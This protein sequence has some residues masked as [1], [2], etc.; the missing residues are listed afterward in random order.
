[1]R[2]PPVS[3]FADGQSALVLKGKTMRISRYL[4]RG[5]FAV[6]A[7]LTLTLG[8]VT[9]AYAD[10]F[11][12]SGNLSYRSTEVKRLANC[13]AAHWYNKSESGAKLT[14]CD[15]ADKDAYWDAIHLSAATQME[16][17]G[18]RV[19][20]YKGACPP[21]RGYAYIKCYYVGGRVRG[22]PVMTVAVESSGLGGMTAHVTWYYL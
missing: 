15:N 12:V 20:Y 16:I 4:E 11:K 9:S 21:K 22:N 18:E 14:G 17:V 8:G 6:A 2:S 1:M 3:T 7:V 13:A 10:S 5:V 19:G